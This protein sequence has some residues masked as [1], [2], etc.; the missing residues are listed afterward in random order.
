M[1]FGVLDHPERGAL[2]L[3]DF[4]GAEKGTGSPF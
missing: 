2:P 3:K 1:E 4:Y